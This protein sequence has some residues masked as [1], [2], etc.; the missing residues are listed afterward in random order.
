MLVLRKGAMAN[1]MTKH[2]RSI[3]HK[4][5]IY[6]V[7]NTFLSTSFKLILCDMTDLLLEIKSLVYREYFEKHSSLLLIYS[8]SASLSSE[9]IKKSTVGCHVN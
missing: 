8:G 3:S 5:S 6:T 1:I 7:L 4:P 9:K 2:P